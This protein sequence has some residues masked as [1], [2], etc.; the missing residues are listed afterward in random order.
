MA[1]WKRFRGGG[2]G[3]PLVERISSSRTVRLGNVQPQAPGHR[4]VFCNDREANAI[5]KFKFRRVT[6]LYFLMISILSCTHVSPCKS[7]YKCASI[8]I[9][10]SC[11]SHKRSMGGLETSSK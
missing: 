8:D 9:G 10:A 2:D 4:T 7:N 11:I 3:A 5:A 1:T 6:N